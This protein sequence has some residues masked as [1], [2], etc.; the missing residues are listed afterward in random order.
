M[1]KTRIITA[2]CL[3][4]V[5]LGVYATASS[6]VWLF[7]CVSIAGL[8]AWEWA[9]MTPI[10]HFAVPF[11]VSLAL[12][13]LVLGWP[14]GAAGLAYVL[15]IVAMAFWLFC[16]PIWLKCS[17]NL[18]SKFI[19]I[20]VGV[21]LIVPS[22]LALN[23]MGGYSLSL[24]LLCFVPVWVA[25]SAAYFCGKAWGL[26]KL[27]PNI[28]PGKTWE[29]ALGGLLGVWVY[30][31]LM[32]YWLVSHDASSPNVG[33]GQWLIL[34]VMLTVFTVLSV[35]GD[36]FESL[37]KRK[38]GFKD[39]SQLLPGHGGVLDRIDSLTST[40]PFIAFVLAT[41]APGVSG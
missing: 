36:L 1:L 10:A 5:F 9:R 11:G 32:G 20:L 28:S 17:W 31:A 25:D 6:W 30:G 13:V 3:L 8:A 12:M 15:W 40:L 24:I 26:H 7:M 23:F 14:G 39:S 22:A 35:T 38:A 18:K 41:A 16:V 29:G 2:L 33:L 21:I 19:S 4:A 34:F 27:A 37:I